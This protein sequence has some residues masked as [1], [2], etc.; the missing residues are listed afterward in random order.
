[1][2]CLCKKCGCKDTTSKHKLTKEFHPKMMKCDEDPS[3]FRVDLDALRNRLDED[4]GVKFTEAECIGIPLSKLP[5][6]EKENELGLCET[7]KQR[8]EL[9]V[10]PAE[11]RSEA[12][13]LDDMEGQLMRTFETLFPKKLKDD[14]DDSEDGEAAMVTCGEPFKGWCHHCGEMGHRHLIA[15]TRRDMI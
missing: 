9:D 11:V 14:T 6:S 7:T 2:G 3:K 4:C 1:M 15:L 10:K 8:I 5:D 13:T 12:H